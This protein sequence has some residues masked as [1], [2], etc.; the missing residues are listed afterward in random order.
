MPDMYTLFC[1]V[2]VLDKDVQENRNLL[3]VGIKLKSWCVFLGQSWAH[4]R[5]V[6]FILSLTTGL[7]SPQYHQKFDDKFETFKHF[8][9]NG[10]WQ[11]K[12][13][14][15]K[16]IATTSIGSPS[17]ASCQNKSR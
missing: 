2:Y 4:A 8:P 11:S 12:C 14:F 6:G 10:L 17:I 13:H 16:I 1:P 3:Q 9:T 15:A 7:T 5:S